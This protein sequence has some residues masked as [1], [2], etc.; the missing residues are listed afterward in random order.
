MICASKSCGLALN[1][2]A[3]WP[4]YRRVNAEVQYRRLTPEQRAD[5]VA[6]LFLLGRLVDGLP[7]AVFMSRSFVIL[8]SAG[9]LR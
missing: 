2:C 7:P 8:N 9:R 1:R 5:H 4:R 3:I 6:A